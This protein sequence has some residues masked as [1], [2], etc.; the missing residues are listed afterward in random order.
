MLTNPLTH[1][2]RK[3]EA[4]LYS[5]NVTVL[6]HERPAPKQESMMNGNGIIDIIREQMFLVSLKACNNLFSLNK[7]T[8]KMHSTRH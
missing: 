8:H 3:S 7:K 5:E 1:C 6:S 2:S 4:F